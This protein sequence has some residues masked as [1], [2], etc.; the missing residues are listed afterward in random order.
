MLIEEEE[1]EEDLSELLL[2]RFV[3]VP[4]TSSSSSLKRASVKVGSEIAE[5][6]R[7]WRGALI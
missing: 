2:F 3:E 1:E 5:E 6:T 4:E 7:E